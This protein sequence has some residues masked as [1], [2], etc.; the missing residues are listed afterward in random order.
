MSNTH[1]IRHSIC[2]STSFAFLGNAMKN[3]Y[4]KL[5]L[6][7]NQ[8]TQSLDSYEQFILRALAGGVTMIQLRDKNRNTAELKTIAA[9]LKAHAQ[10]F[11]IP[12]IINDH[13]Q[14]AKEVDA[15]GVHLGQSDVSPDEA[16][17]ILGPNKIIGWSVEGLVDIEFANQSTSIDYIAASAI[18]PSKNKTNCKTHWGLSGLQM[19]TRKSIHP[20]VA[21]GGIDPLNICKVMANGASGI[22]VISA[23][24]DASNTELATRHLLTQIDNVL[25]KGKNANH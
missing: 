2:S 21:I 6:V 10:K 17:Y 14:L 25:N 22:A 11:H 8:N 18:F 3:S 4:L 20:I 15:D 1:S 24:H 9:Q 5:C 12:F 19:I 7:T 16:R 23:L 13:V